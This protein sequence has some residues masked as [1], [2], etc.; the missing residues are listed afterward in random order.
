MI[1]FS[2]IFLK[3]ALAI[4]AADSSTGWSNINREIDNLRLLNEDDPVQDHSFWEMAYI[5]NSAL[6]H[7]FHFS[8]TTHPPD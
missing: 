1:D 3:I 6:L 2:L 5:M 4:E 7:T 8:Y